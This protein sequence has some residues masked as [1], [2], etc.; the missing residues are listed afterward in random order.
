MMERIHDPVLHAE[1][2]RTAQIFGRAGVITLARTMQVSPERVKQMLADG[3]FSEAEIELAKER[4][5]YEA[6]PP[7]DI[8][9]T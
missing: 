5:L 8:G 7:S 1:L 4:E 3:M 2:R 6:R 9:I